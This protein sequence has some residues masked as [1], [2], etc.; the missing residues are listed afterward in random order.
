MRLGD[1]PAFSRPVAFSRPRFLP[2]LKTA[3][4]AVIYALVFAPNAWAKAPDAAR[5]IRDLE[6]TIP[7]T[8]PAA[9]APPVDMQAPA[10][11]VPPSS[12][13]VTTILL[14]GFQLEG[15]QVYD[16]PTLQALLADL[17]GTRQ[18]LNGL[19]AAAARITA[20]YL[21]DGYPLA[22]AY[23]PAQEVAQGVV[24]IGVLEGV[25][26]EVTVNNASRVRSGVLTPALDALRSG[27]AVQ[28]AQLDG[29]LLRLN[30][31]PGVLAKGTL[32]AGAT[33]GSTDLVIN[34]EP[35]PW[36]SG[37]LAADNY[38]G[39]YTGEY[40][41]SAAASLHSP[42]ALG[43]QLD[44]RLLSSDHQQRYY[45]AD[46]S[47]PMGPWPVRLGAGAS[48]MRYALGREFSVL[49]AH[50]SAQTTTLYLRQALLRSRDAAIQA[51]L[52]YEHKRFQDNYDAVDY[53]QAHRVG[54]WTAS[55]NASLNDTLFG[56]GRSAGYLAYSRGNLRMGS[57]A[58]RR[59]DRRI[60]Q[61]GG[62][63]G[64]VN[65]S[66]SRLQHMTGPFQFQGRLRAQWASKNL[67]S[68][69]KFGLGGPYGVR[70]F[71]P[72]A[73]SADQG[74]QASGELRYLPLPG[75]QLSAFVDTGS[76]QTNRRAWT[77]E[78]NRQS[79]TAFGVGVAHAG[80]QHFINV[81]AA[82]PLRQSMPHA[83]TDQEPRFWV[84]ATRYF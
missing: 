71:A 58:L 26:G 80:P 45:H 35:G 48:N 72:G 10:P 62:G 59:D 24:R 64:V 65:I 12:D 28:A 39:A 67:Y 76:V 66:L 9:P 78:R 19:R 49:D 16:T 50:G 79:L 41:L 14:Q 68:S 31:I 53:Q 81:N 1:S 20:H 34:A 11:P 29:A 3:S 56:G 55:L 73:G 25:Y 27:Q 69:E 75:L 63:F 46:Y 40:R 17:I 82:W 7:A 52:Q 38:G 47:V 2:A 44:L 8:L 70:A 57:A 54:L 30:D 5:A 74:W 13:E 36:I 43:D 77:N 37:S 51:T 61:A 60:R 15:N 18:D 23:L 32:R 22:R 21:R 33:P 6:S 84:Q 42:L 83:K 4:Q